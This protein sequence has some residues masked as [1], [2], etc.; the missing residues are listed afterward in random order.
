[1]QA[2]SRAVG[3][4]TGLAVRNHTIKDLDNAGDVDG[5]GLYS[6]TAQLIQSFVELA[7][8]AEGRI[9]KLLDM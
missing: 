2:R 4:L 1:L 6:S 9:M 8:D 5:K 7:L 3:V